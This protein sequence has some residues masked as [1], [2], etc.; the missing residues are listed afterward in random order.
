[1]MRPRTIVLASAFLGGLTWASGCGEDTTE[2][3]QP[4]EPLRPTAVT[5]SPSAAELT[6]VG[7]TVQLSTEVRDQNGRVMTGVAV[8]WLSANIAVAR[9]DA[10]GLVTSTGNGTIAIT[11][12]AGTASASASV[13]VAQVVMGIE[14]LPADGKVSAGDTLRVTAEAWDANGFTVP[15][16]EF[17]WSSSDT[18]VATVDGSGLVRGIV[19]GAALITATQASVE[20]AA[21]ITVA[22]QDWGPLAALYEDTNGPR[23]TE[24]DGWMSDLPIGQWDGV[25]TGEGGYVTG[26]DLVGSNMA[27]PIPAR[28]G[29]LAHLE[30]LILERNRLT[31][32]IPVELADLRGLKTLNLGVNDLSGQIPPELGNLTNLEDLRLRRNYLTGPIPP[33]IGNL[34]KLARLT[35]HGSR[36]TGP[37]PSTFLDLERLRLFHFASSRSLCAPGSADFTEWIAQLEV[38]AGPWCNEDDREVLASLYE[39]TGGSEWTRSNGWSG[40]GALFE[41]HG[42]QTDSLGRVLTLDLSS[43]G[44][45]GQVPES[46]GELTGITTLQI[47]GNE[48]LIGPLPLSLTA[49]SLEELD[50]GQTGLCVPADEAFA[51]WLAAIPS[52]EGTDT[53]CEP[54]SERSILEQL[55]TETGGPNWTKDTNWLSDQPLGEWHGVETDE[56]GRVV[57]LRLTN[58]K[59][60]GRIPPQIGA[61]AQLRELALNANDLTGPIPPRLGRLS[62]L[63]RMDLSRNDLS[64][65]IPPELGALS[66][67]WVLFLYSNELTG[68]IPAELAELSSLRGLGLGLNRL[69]GPIPPELGALSNLTQF[70]LD[71]NQLTGPIPPELGALSNL[72]ELILARNRLSGS[73]PVGLGRLPHL[74][75]LD[76]SHNDL[77]GSI[78]TGLGQLS[79]LSQLSLNDNRLSGSIPS[80]LGNLSNLERLD[81]ARNGLTGTMPAQLGYL[82]RLTQLHINE[83]ELTGAIPTEFGQLSRLRSLSIPGNQLSGSF[84]PE[85]SGITGL[86]Q[87]FLTDNAGMSGTLPAILTAL[88]TLNAL[89][90]TGTGL[91]AP[92]DSSFQSW[93]SDVEVSRVRPCETG[94]GSAAYLIQ[95][96]QTLDFPVPLVADREALLRVFVTAPRPAGERIPKVRATFHVD[97]VETNTVEIPGSG[98][99]IPA[100]IDEAESSLDRSANVT[101]PGSFIRPGLEMVIEIDPDQTLDPGLGVTRRIPETGRAAVRVESMPLLHLTVIPFQLVTDPDSSAIDMTRQMAAEPG[102]HEWLTHTHSMLPVGGLEVSAHEPVLTSTNDVIDLLLETRMIQRLEDGE[103][104]YMGIM[105]ERALGGRSGVAYGGLPTNFSAADSLVIAHELGHNMSLAHVPCGAPAG[106]DPAFPTSDGT[107]GAWGYDNRGNGRLISPEVLDLMSYCGPPHWASDYS[108]TKAL[109]YRLARETGPGQLARAAVPTPAPSLILWGGVDQQGVPYLEPAFVADAPPAVAGSTGQYRLVG[110]DATGNELFSLYV[111]MAEVADADGGSHFV[112]ALPVE[113]RWAGALESITLSGLGGSVTTNRATDTPLAILRDPESGQVRGILRGEDATDLIGVAADAV[114]PIGP[115]LRVLFSR[116][117]PDVEDWRR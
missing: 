41:L 40:D 16:T 76:L 110:Q 13:T 63:S 64:G 66:N 3:P 62:G 114:G 35:L 94:S 7:E 91:C 108:F 65:V 46:L 54:L 116:G 34:R 50:Y 49:L 98:I 59:L 75:R 60:T 1:M 82:S 42:V 56:A 104:Y 32:P 37:I 36:L 73:I 14:M 113:T 80:T 78:P 111:D 15:D 45:A 48:G 19:E 33:E 20:G 68:P 103:G 23:W 22:H 25:T 81:L 44:L 47:D 21:V 10:T 4:P 74:R 26:L 92:A 12:R 90:L 5:V 88:D 17:T 96:V 30:T 53:E 61:L 101:I 51:E 99:P 102:T 89:V 55:Y 79:G 100:G 57:V 86:R 52:H 117:L 109:D 115:D 87:L 31:G 85:L 27:G 43:N 6:A 95:S 97:G 71:G 11:A 77:T 39:A 38:A 8:T 84:P 28:L 9:V 70:Y 112:A 107:I 72:V 69:T 106:V 58:N 93:L 29:S 105:P 83:N 24:H 67:L 2:P 18:A